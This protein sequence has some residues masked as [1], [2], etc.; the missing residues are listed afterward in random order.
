MNLILFLL[1]IIAV[2]LISVI[3]T[4][5]IAMDE[6][7][8]INELNEEIKDKQKSIAYLYRHARELAKLRAEN[9]KKKEELENAKTDEE[10]AVIVASVI[11]DNNRLCNGKK[12]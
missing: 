7:N 1:L 4:A 9:D 6:K 5:K 12:D 8:K 10:I 3:L 11:A 2:L